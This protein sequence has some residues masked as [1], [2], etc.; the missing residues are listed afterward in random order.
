MTSQATQP[1]PTEVAVHRP[2]A[3]QWR[4]ARDRALAEAGLTY[5]ELAEQARTRSFQSPQALILWVTFG[6]EEV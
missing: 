6:D 4:Q 3:H 1:E 5:P 2:T